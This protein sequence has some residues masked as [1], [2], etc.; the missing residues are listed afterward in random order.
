M[1]SG[2]MQE[3]DEI[4]LYFKLLKEKEDKTYLLSSFP[5]HSYKFLMSDKLTLDTNL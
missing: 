1:W 3:P 4:I 5:N 2:V